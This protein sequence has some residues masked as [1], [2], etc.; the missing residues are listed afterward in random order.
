MEKAKLPQAFVPRGTF[1]LSG[2]LL[3]ELMEEYKGENFRNVPRGTLGRGQR[4]TRGTE[5][6]K[7]TS[8][9]RSVRSYPMF[10]PAPRMVATAF[11]TVL[12]NGSVSWNTNLRFFVVSAQKRS[13]IVCAR[14]PR[15]QLYHACEHIARESRAD[16]CT[17][18]LHAR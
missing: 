2:V 3:W 11:S 10:M 17:H 4:D 15:F 9:C 13:I 18:C 14:S 6:D 5:M 12:K 16:S 1:C 8:L 7:R